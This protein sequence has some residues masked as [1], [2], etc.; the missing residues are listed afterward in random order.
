MAGLGKALRLDQEVTI[1]LAG[2]HELV[3]RIVLAGLPGSASRDDLAGASSSLA[4]LGLPVPVLPPGTADDGLRRRL[5]MAVYR[6]EQEA[7]EKVSRLGGLADTWLFA[8]P[9]PLE[10]C[11]SAGVIGCPA[12]AVQLAGEP[13]LATLLAAARAGTELAAVSFDTLPRSAI[14]QAL[15]MLGIAADDVHVREHITSPASLA[16]YHARLWRLSQTSAAV[17]CLDDVARRLAANRVPVFTVRPTGMAIASALEFATLTAG[18]RV[19]AE[20]QFAVALVEVPALRDDGEHVSRQAQEEVRLTVRRFLV[21]E[22][23]RIDATVSRASDCGFLVL[24][25]RGSIAAAGGERPFAARARTALGL[26]LEVGVGTGRT[27]R[28]AEERARIRLREH[29]SE[30]SPP[31]GHAAAQLASQA[32]PAEE[33]RTAEVRRPRQP[34]DSLSR[35]RSLETLARLAQKL[36]ADASPVVDAELTGQLLSVTPRTARRQ[37]RALADQGL[38]LPLPPSRTQHPGRPRH[39]YRLVLEKLDRRAAL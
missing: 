23:Q 5:L 38:A 25:T 16:S 27:E 2:P 8:S 29:R 17:T 36:A 11:R 13:L 21:R 24:G 32:R 30:G 10:Y 20:S 19:L 6:S 1:G 15:S 28:E 39:A 26:D 18:R 9:A 7:P 33:R 14:M 37:L 34:A 12:I 4:A 31:A 22:A 3:E 35:L